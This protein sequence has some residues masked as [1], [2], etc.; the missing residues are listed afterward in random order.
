M[1][2]RIDVAFVFGSVARAA[3]TQGS[4]VDLLIIGSID[5]GTVVD[6]L[7]TKVKSCATPRGTD[8][9]SASDLHC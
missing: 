9:I 6:A 1:T 5:F 3:E 2:D 7:H 8:L 4:D